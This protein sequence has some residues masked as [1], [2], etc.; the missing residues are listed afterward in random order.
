MVYGAADP[1]ERVRS[2]LVEISGSAKVPPAGL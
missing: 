1:T 2:I